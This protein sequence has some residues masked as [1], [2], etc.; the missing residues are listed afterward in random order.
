MFTFS[1]LFGRS[2]S[3]NAR[4]RNAIIEVLETRVLLA[5]LTSSVRGFKFIDTNGNGVKDP[6]E[7]AP[8]DPQRFT[9]QA[10]VTDSLGTKTFT[11]Q[12]WLPGDPQPSGVTLKAG[13]FYFPISAQRN[14]GDAAPT[15]SIQ[16]LPTSGWTQTTT[17][18]SPLTIVANGQTFDYDVIL[19]LN[20]GNFQNAQIV[21]RKFNDLN[22]NGVDDSDPGVSNWTVFLDTNGNNNLDSGE[23]STTTDSS[24]NYT[25]ENLG[26]GSYT[27]REVQQAGW[28]Q[29]TTNPASVTVSS[30]ATS[31]G[32]NF[33]NF[34]TVQLTG[35]KFND[36]NG[37]GVDN[38]DPG[39]ADWQIFLDSNGNNVL[40]PGEVS[41]LTNASG[42]YTFSNLGP[43]TY[44]VREVQNPAW[45]Q[46]TT[47]PGSVTVASGTNTNGGNFGNFLL[48][49]I[50]GQKFNDLNGNGSK[51]SGDTGLAVW[52][53]FND[54]ND[55]GTLDSGEES[56]VTGPGGSY[57]L[58]LGPG[59]VRIR[60]VGQT[61]WIQT[62]SNPGSF[63][64]ISGTTLANV[65]FGNFKKYS[66]TGLKFE[67]LNGNGQLDPGEPGLA[68]WTIFNDAN[69]NS[70]LD[71]GEA[72]TTT[73]V[74]GSYTLNLGPGTYRIRE[75][76][77]TG[78]VQTL[79]VPD[80]NGQSGINV[81]GGN[82]GNF[83]LVTI[84]GL[85]FNDLNGDQNPA[86]EPGLGGW[87]IFDDVNN[88]GQLDSGEQF[89]TTASNGT[90][91][92]TNV[93]PRQLR[94][95]EVQ[96]TGWQQTT[97]NP[98]V[99]S[100]TSGVNRGDLNF[101]NRQQTG[102][103]S[104]FKFNDLNGNGVRDSGEPGIENWTIYLDQNFNGQLDSGETSVKTTSNGSF[105][106]DALPPGTYRVREVLTAGWQ[107]TTTNPAD[108][109]LAGG[110]SQTGLLFGNFQQVSISGAKF[111]D[112]NANGVRDTGEA[113][114]S[115]W[116]IFLDTN[117]NGVLDPGER[118]QLTDSNGNYSFSNVGP[119]TFRLR[120]VAQFNWI[121]MT[122]NP[123]VTTTSGV[124]VGGQLFGNIKLDDMVKLGKLVMTSS[125]LKNFQSGTMASQAQFIAN[126][127]LTYKKPS[128]LAGMCN[129]LKL[130]MAGY[131]SSFVES[132][133]KQDFGIV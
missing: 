119:G 27:V 70:I 37:D 83:K 86:G 82:L 4:S 125:N 72:S 7:G 118:S 108:V 67:D 54:R 9:F 120:E 103:I 64:G 29:T 63:A 8:P 69:G 6:T 26:P 98:P 74:N 130:F 58:K 65:D 32:G 81:V 22:G 24:G 33:G 25:F 3:R 16:E 73:G 89:T 128:S 56:T 117:N 96:Q 101:G 10:T 52:T 131:S 99:F 34:R 78:W 132:K 77:Q 90:W 102:S 95:R 97:A 109:V 71:S 110:Q 31:N 46:T 20:V 5:N 21:G 122:A 68:G 133:F 44:T 87:T 47:N 14:P 92:F 116:T 105:Q 11:T 100:T 42:I 113:G 61:D 114:L 45:I 94:I 17:I 79:G 53:I 60:E 38:S 66:L 41:T 80:G 115:G 55:N 127:Y 28:I 19:G 23:V 93:G 48:Q 111:N 85:K 57:T 1:K 112:L 49:T 13:E 15:I 59:I 35:K 84:S 39:V 51:D 2:Q 106:F 30:G 126:L 91:S 40:D 88:N 123:I 43:G 62:T 50:S 107:Q 76:L 104:G 129:Y 18:L 75:V 124:N 36:L 12:N 121:Q